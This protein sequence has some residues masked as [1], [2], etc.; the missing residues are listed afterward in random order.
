M[1]AGHRRRGA[2]YERARKRRQPCRTTSW[3]TAG[4]RQTLRWGMLASGGG[5]VAGRRGA[6]AVVVVLGACATMGP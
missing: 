4:R 2:T 1:S 3:A 6:C 5:A